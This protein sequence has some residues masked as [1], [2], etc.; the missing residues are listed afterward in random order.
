MG[1]TGSG[2]SAARCTILGSNQDAVLTSTQQ[3]KKA[4]G[5]AA[6]REVMV[7]D[8]P[9]W[10]SPEL[11]LEK[12]REDLGLSVHLSDPGPHA[13]LLVIPVKQPRGEERGMLEKMEEIFGE[14][15]WETALILFTVS[16]E[17][18]KKNIQFIHSGNQEVQELK[19]KCKNRF[20]CL[21]TT[22]TGDDSQVSELL[23]KIEKMVEGN[24]K[25]FFSSEIYLKT[26]DYLGKIEKKISEIPAKV[27]M[28]NAKEQK[29]KRKPEQE[30]AEERAQ[31][32][33]AEQNVKKLKD[34]TELG[35]DEEERNKMAFAL[36]EIWKD[37]LTSS[38]KMQEDLKESKN[39]LKEK[40]RQIENMNKQLHEKEKNIET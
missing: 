10:F 7:V 12:L 4:E 3:S 5:K 26:L 17:E 23:E 1:R 18:Q 34:N 33:K 32:T 13:F 8:T 15:C 27:F 9:D 20:H 14:G 6:G 21:D 31:S 2:K 19:E 28:G 37:I 16:E 29:T 30:E 40:D 38:M 36:H 39:Q 11:C 24:S 35:V 22:A 25:K